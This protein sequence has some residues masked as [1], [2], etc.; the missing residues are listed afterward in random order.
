MKKFVRKVKRWCSNKLKKF[1]SVGL[2][3][4]HFTVISNNCTGGYVYQHFGLGYNSPTAGLFFQAKV[5]VKLSADCEHYFSLDLEFIKPEESKNHEL[6]KDTNGWG[7]Y[8]VARLGDIEIYFM[9]YKTPEEAEEKWVRRKN[10]ADLKN[11]VYMYCENEGCTKEDIE[12]FL[13]IPNKNLLCFTFNDYNVQGA[14][15]SKE[16]HEMEGH[17]WKPEIVMSMIDWKK[18]LNQLNK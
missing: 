9:H 10:R 6:F 13:S 5:F 4:K 15:F 12:S 8:P 14:K 2:K 18:Y 16:V 3:N 17:P 1:R 7:S 11:A